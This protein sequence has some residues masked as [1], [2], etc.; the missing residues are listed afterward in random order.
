[1]AFNESGKEVEAN[2]LLATVFINTGSILF[3]SAVDT[4]KLNKKGGFSL[5][6][7]STD[8]GEDS[9]FLLTGGGTLTPSFTYGNMP[10]FDNGNLIVPEP[11]SIAL[12]ALGGLALIRRRRV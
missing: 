9:K 6:L 8:I 11:T 12:L 2:G 7:S 10:A 1:M 4:F 3:N 5:M